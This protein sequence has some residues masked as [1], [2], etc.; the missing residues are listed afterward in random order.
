MGRGKADA[1]VAGFAGT[2]LPPRRAMAQ[3]HVGTLFYLPLRGRAECLRMMLHFAQL[4]FTDEVISNEDWPARKASMPEGRGA[5]F[6]NRP[7]GNRGLP[8]L[9]LPDGSLMPESTDIASHI[10]AAAGPPLLPADPEAAASAK[11]LYDQSQSLPLAWPMVC[12]VRFPVEQAEAIMNGEIL[13]EWMAAPRSFADLLPALRA[14]VVE[15]GDRPF[16]G[17]DHPHYGDFGVWKQADSF[18]LLDPAASAS[19]G[20][21]WGAWIDRVASLPGVAEY[22]AQRP[23]L[24]SKDAGYPGSIIVECADPSSR[25]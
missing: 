4:P 3:P 1:D 21:A 2:A 23:G 17:G 10:A 11:R 16:F 25:I 13:G 20:S 19:L 12:L 5:E 9:Q 24:R 8:V 14:L 18:R 6:P 22:L 15:L 7:V